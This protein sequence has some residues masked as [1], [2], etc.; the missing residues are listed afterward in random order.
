MKCPGFFSYQIRFHGGPKIGKLDG[1]VLTW[2]IR[3]Q[4]NYPRRFS[5]TMCMLFR[6]SCDKPPS[7]GWSLF[8]ACSISSKIHKRHTHSLPLYRA[9][10]VKTFPGHTHTK[11]SLPFSIFCHREI[12]SLTKLAFANIQSAVHERVEARDFIITAIA[13]I[14]LSRKRRTTIDKYRSNIILYIY[15]ILWSIID[16]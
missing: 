10:V 6:S 9:S 14:L 16:V 5:R 8:I 3:R 11:N 13:I 7:I 12:E 4:P 1:R 2:H 15:S